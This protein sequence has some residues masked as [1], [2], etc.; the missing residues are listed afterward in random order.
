MAASTRQ[1]LTSLLCLLSSGTFA[2]LGTK[3]LTVELDQVDEGEQISEEL[4]V[5][6]RQRTVREWDEGVVKRGTLV[7]VYPF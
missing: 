6:T 5:V 2:Q 1:P 7:C 3:V 4:A